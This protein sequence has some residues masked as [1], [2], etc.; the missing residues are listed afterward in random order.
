[1]TRLVRRQWIEESCR[2]FSESTGWPL[3]FVDRAHLP[4]DWEAAPH[5]AGALCVDLP[6]GY[7]RDPQWPAVRQLAHVL[8]EFINRVLALESTE[9]SELQFARRMLR[10]AREIARPLP[11]EESLPRLLELAV[12]VANADGAAF[13][14]LDADAPQLRLRAHWSRVGMTVPTSCRELHGSVPDLQSMVKGPVAVHRTDFPGGCRWLPED[15]EMGVCLGLRSHTQPIGTLWAYHRR[16]RPLPRVDFELLRT[17]A[18]LLATELDRAVLTEESRDRQRLRKELRAAAPLDV[19][20]V[21]R[22][23]QTWPFDVALRRAS[24]EQIGGDLCE[25]IAVDEQTTALVVGDA[26][27]DSI[28]AAIIRARVEGA[29]HEV[30]QSADARQ[31][32]TDAVAAR[33]NRTLARLLPDDQ[34]CSLFLAFWQRGSRALVC[35][36]A[37]HPAPLVIR[38]GQRLELKSHG[39]LLGIMESSTYHQTRLR[40][41]PGDWLCVCTDGVGDTLSRRGSSLA[42]LVDERL[43]NR[44]ESTADELADAIWKTSNLE[45]TET[46]DDRSLMVVRFA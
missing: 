34:F 31:G 18:G 41:E 16:S 1:M 10:V 40:L 15:C 39:M 30:L 22:D 28:P 26:T 45:Q 42:S 14:L 29:L 3:V 27:G 46:T 4:A 5:A 24:R 19:G 21:S 20:D 13:F 12:D 35:T 2:R 37:G 33:L 23:G 38:A 36:N 32:R 7:E 44:P 8:S 11:V 6:S 17:I 43:R 9:T 25:L